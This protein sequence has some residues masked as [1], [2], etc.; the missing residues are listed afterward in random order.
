MKLNQTSS[1]AV[2]FMS[3]S[4]SLS[5]NVPSLLCVRSR[6]FRAISDYGYCSCF[7]STFFEFLNLSIR[8]LSSLPDSSIIESL[9]FICLTASFLNLSCVVRGSSDT[10]QFFLEQ[11]VS[12]LI[13]FSSER[14][15]S[16]RYS[17]I[18]CFEKS[19]LESPAPFWAPDAPP[20]PD[21]CF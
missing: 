9:P 8:S 12:V 20:S 18:F 10:G 5:L 19:P 4:L 3:L 2:V 7:C 21:V 17:R 14:S 11:A 15:F 1:A 6:F 16:I 13:R